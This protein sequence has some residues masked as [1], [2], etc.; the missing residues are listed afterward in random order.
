MTS[1]VH[2]MMMLGSTLGF[3]AIVDT[4]KRLAVHG[5]L[6]PIK[7]L[8]GKAEREHTKHIHAPGI[9]TELQADVREGH[10]EEE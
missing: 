1:V 8:I 3:M 6:N 10:V 5:G 4:R 7:R 2:F 9:R